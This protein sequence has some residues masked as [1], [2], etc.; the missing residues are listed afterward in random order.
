MARIC[1]RCVYVRLAAGLPSAFG[2]AVR[3]EVQRVPMVAP[4]RYFG[5]G[6]AKKRSSRWTRTSGTS[7][8]LPSTPQRTTRNSP[9]FANAS[10]MRP[11]STSGSQ[12]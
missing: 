11:L 5:A 2:P 1:S 3:R 12:A 6:V 7:Y 4:W 9:R 10:P 8:R